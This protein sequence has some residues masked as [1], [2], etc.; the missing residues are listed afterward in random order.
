MGLVVGVC[1][2]FRAQGRFCVRDI[3][4]E[5]ESPSTMLLLHYT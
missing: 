2:E 4:G 5:V 1:L 3:L